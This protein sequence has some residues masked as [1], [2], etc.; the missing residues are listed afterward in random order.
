MNALV[1]EGIHCG[2][3]AWEA[4]EHE[5]MVS[6]AKPDSWSLYNVGTWRAL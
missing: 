3:S 5:T 1:K 2:K 4:T 6:A